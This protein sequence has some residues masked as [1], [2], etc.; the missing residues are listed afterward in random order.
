[1]NIREYLNQA[2]VLGR[3][4]DAKKE[5]LK[6]L[7]ISI[8]LTT[9]S[10]LLRSL[11]SEKEKIEAEIN[12]ELKIRM[13]IFDIIEKV[14]DI[15]LKSLLQYKYICGMTTEEIAEKLNFAPRHI[16]RM[17]IKAVEEAEKYYKIA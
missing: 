9:D 7:D 2:F 14:E 4:I 3:S 16:F 17:N 1:M 10:L 12:K 8:S 6:T 11:K 15:T 5:V 13:N